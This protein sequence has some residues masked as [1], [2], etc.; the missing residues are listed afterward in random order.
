MH[1]SSHSAVFLRVLID[2]QILFNMP[3]QLTSIFVSKWTIKLYDALQDYQIP[4]TDPNSSSIGWKAIKDCNIDQVRR[5]CPNYPDSRPNEVNSS[6]S[7]FENPVQRLKLLN[8]R[9]NTIDFFSPKDV[10][11]LTAYCC[12]PTVYDVPHLG[13]ARTFIWFDCFLNF[14][15]YG[16]NYKVR[17]VMN[18]TDMDDKIMQRGGIQM[19]REY[20]EIFFETMDKLNVKRPDFTPRASEFLKVAKNMFNYLDEKG[21]VLPANINGDCRFDIHKYYDNFDP[22]FPLTKTREKPKDGF[23]VWKKK[24]YDDLKEKPGWH[25]ECACIN[26]FYFGD[27]IDLHFGGKDLIFPHHENEIALGRVLY[28]NPDWVRFV[29][30]TG[31]LQ[32]E[33]RKM[34]KSLKNF[35]TVRELFEKNYPP[36]AIRYYFLKHPYNADMNFKEEELMHAHRSYNQF[37]LH[38]QN[39]EEFSKEGEPTLEVPN[40]E[41][42][43]RVQ[44]K[45]EECL[46]NNLN[47]AGALQIL[48]DFVKNFLPNIKEK[49]FLAYCLKYVKFVADKWF[50]LLERKTKNECIVPIV[51]KFRHKIRESVLNQKRLLEKEDKCLNKEKLYD[52][53]MKQLSHCDVVREELSE[54]NIIVEDNALKE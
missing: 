35:I 28:D 9:T 10:K 17:S 24:T 4:V 51:K 7:N 52:E 15:T 50:G 20:E 22:V 33:N 12:G 30:H 5:I 41:E 23:L 46:L 18:I 40:C 49:C 25:M 29:V 31:H 39:L 53:V 3:F 14:L 19:A 27:N 43:I 47:V 21:Y 8:S 26:S 6:N 16:M 38:L 42:L 45:I 1:Q 54:N 2:P 32:I 44:Q 48:E 37:I 13:H 11:N 34:S 36:L